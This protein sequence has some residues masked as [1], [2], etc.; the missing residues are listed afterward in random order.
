MIRITKNILETFDGRQNLAVTVEHQESRLLGNSFR[1]VMTA[2]IE[3]RI[4]TAAADATDDNW[5][6]PLLLEMLEEAFQQ[7]EARAR[8]AM[9]LVRVPALQPAPQLGGA[10]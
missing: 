6:E 9:E 5:D 3:V 10:A 1:D 8:Q 4:L 2:D 7:I